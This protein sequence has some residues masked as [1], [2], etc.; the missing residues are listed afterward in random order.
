M[1]DIKDLAWNLYCEA[2][3][4]ALSAV[5]DWEQLGPNT[6]AEYLE[7][8]ELCIDCEYCTTKCEHIAPKAG[9]AGKFTCATFIYKRYP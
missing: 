1:T 3:K 5:D 6:Q 2:T 7:R 8:A 4:G 9:H